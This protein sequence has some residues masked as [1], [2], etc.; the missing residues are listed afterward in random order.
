MNKRGS[1]AVGVR[2]YNER[3]ILATVRRLNGASK[4]DLSRITG[5]SPQAAVRIVESL[6]NEG[7]LIKAGKR[8]GGMGQPSVIYQIN[9]DSGCTIGA[10]IGRDRLV[11]TM[12]DFD[13]RV[14]ACE[15]TSAPYPSPASAVEHIQSFARKYMPQLRK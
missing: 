4:A 1:N 3:L 9:G 5:L 15:S 13:G 8:T 6:A 12:L 14:I 10:E 7:R 2:R 11:C